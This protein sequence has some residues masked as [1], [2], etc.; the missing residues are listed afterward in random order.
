M[1]F[2]ITVSC[3]VLARGSLSTPNP[4]RESGSHRLMPLILFR[5]SSSSSVG[6]TPS[7]NNQLHKNRPLI[8]ASKRCSRSAHLSTKCVANHLCIFG[9]SSHCV[10]YSTTGHGY[11]E[12]IYINSRFESRVPGVICT[13]SNT[14][15]MSSIINARRCEP[16]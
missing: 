10:G 5:A 1:D 3:R 12:N 15:L 9:V 14:D 2:V 8:V 11:A 13:I 4:G 6:R 7:C 16:G